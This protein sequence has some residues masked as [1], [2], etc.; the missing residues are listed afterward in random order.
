M[1]LLRFPIPKKKI[2]KLFAIRRIINMITQEAYSHRMGTAS[3]LITGKD[4]APLVNTD[5]TVRQV[6]Q[7]VLFGCAAFESVPLVNGELDGIQKEQTEKR[8][9]KV[10]ELFN[11]VTMPFYWGR[12][13]PEQG[14]PDT[15]RIKKTA[16]WWKNQGYTVKGHPLCWH[17]VC[18]PWLLDM[19]DDEILAAQLARIDRDVSDFAGIIDMWDVINEVVIMPI[20]DKYDNAITRICKKNGRI[21]LVKKVFAAAKKANPNATLLINDFEMSE[22][23]DILLEGLLEAGVPI[24]AIGLQSH[25]HQGCWSVEKTEEILERYSRFG[26]PLHFTEINLISGDIMPKHIVDLNDFK[27]DEWPSTPEGEERQATEAA[28]FYKLLFKSPLVE[29]ITYWTF[30]DG[31]WLKAP[32]GLMTADACVKPVYNALHD[33]IKGEWHTPEQRLTTDN[34][35][36]L[37]V[38]GFKGEYEA[39]VDGDSIKFSID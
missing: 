1:R 14:N 12:F 22:S 8:I 17:T 20:F 5:M 4:G 9:Q 21:G 38:T 31:G 37:E 6:K 18:A 15:E 30:T 13:E 34:E 36:I 33:L 24:D 28:A 11:S 2:P 19:S 35:G 7:K 29:A 23:Y 3:P 27:V 32:A 25:M 16:E 26:L 10:R 39:E